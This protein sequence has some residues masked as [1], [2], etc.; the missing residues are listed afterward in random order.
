MF[1][2]KRELQELSSKINS[3]NRDLQRMYQI[4]LKLEYSYYRTDLKFNPI[5]KPETFIKLQKDILGSF[6]SIKLS[7]I[8][9]KEFWTL[10]ENA[11]IFAT[12]K[13]N[14]VILRNRK[15]VLQHIGYYNAGIN[16]FYPPIEL[17]L[18][19]INYTDFVKDFNWR[20]KCNIS[21]ILDECIK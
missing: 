18:R 16:Q 6:K 8:V 14:E 1:S 17:S 11:N 3:N 10:T 21:L 2:I 9:G 7:E 12:Y 5:K 13:V 20:D 4:L 15:L 19:Y